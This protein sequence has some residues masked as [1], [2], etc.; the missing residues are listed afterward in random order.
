V[1]TDEGLA[2]SRSGALTVRAPLGSRRSAVLIAV[3][4]ALLVSGGVTAFRAVRDASHA[5]PVVYGAPS[6]SEAIAVERPR[7]DPLRAT[8]SAAAEQAQQAPTADSFAATR[9]AAAPSVSSSAQPQKPLP[10]QAPAKLKSAPQPS[11][12]RAANTDS[13]APDAER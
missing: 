6:V 2:A 9:P 12:Q 8:V 1:D 3:V 7:S 10:K 4:T 5:E 11:S 13:I